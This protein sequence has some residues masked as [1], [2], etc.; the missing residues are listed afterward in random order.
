MRLWRYFFVVMVPFSIICIV[1]W[2][3]FI[4][5]DPIFSFDLI[6]LRIG[7]SWLGTIFGVAVAF[8]LM[9]IILGSAIF[10][11]TTSPQDITLALTKFKFPQVFVFIFSSSFLAVD[12]LLSDARTILDVM[13]T[14]GIEV[15]KGSIVAR[16]KVA[17]RLIVPLMLM[18]MKRVN[19]LSIILVQ[20]AYDPRAKKRTLVRDTRFTYLD[21]GFIILMFAFLG[22]CISLRVMGYGILIPYRI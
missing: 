14:R 22:I 19:D 9:S 5:G 11:T 7:M 4:P 10:M 21:Y 18:S 1:M 2:S 17:V 12:T 16:I 15:D 8:R 20:R 13:R 3:F 6:G